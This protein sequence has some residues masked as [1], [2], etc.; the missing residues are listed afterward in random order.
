MHSPSG[1]IMIDCFYDAVMV[2]SDSE[3]A[4]IAEIPYEEYQYRHELGVK[5]AYCMMLEQLRK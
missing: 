3:R 4:Q 5:Q 2:L 1:K